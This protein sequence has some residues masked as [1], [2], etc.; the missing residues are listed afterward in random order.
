MERFM[1]F[2]GQNTPWI[3]GFNQPTLWPFILKFGFKLGMWM[4]TGDPAPLNKCLAHMNLAAT[5][6][7]NA[8]WTGAH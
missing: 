5:Q 6:R 7:L 3:L 1:P 8:G 2:L 4:V